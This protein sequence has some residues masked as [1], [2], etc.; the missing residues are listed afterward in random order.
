[1]TRVTAVAISLEETGFDFAELGRLRDDILAGN[2]AE[3]VAVDAGGGGGDGNVWKN[4]WSLGGEDVPV[5][6]GVKG[7]SDDDGGGTPGE[8][9]GKNGWCSVRRL[10]RAAMAPE[11]VQFEIT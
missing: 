7:T 5:G 10:L 1:M 9:C 4:G 6:L 8:S 2:E 11:S 3:G